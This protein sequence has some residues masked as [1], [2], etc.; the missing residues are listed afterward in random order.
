MRPFDITR[1]AISNW[2]D[3]ELNALAVAIKQATDAC[4]DRTPEQF[5]GD[6]LIAYVNEELFPYLKGF[7]QRATCPDT[8]EYKI[9]EIF[10]EIKNKFQS[11]YSLATP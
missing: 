11:G 1:N 8:I 5:S 4:R 2:S 6:D 9:G 3:S 10:G 7:K